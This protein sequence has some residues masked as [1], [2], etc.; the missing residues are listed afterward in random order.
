MKE[1]NREKSRE[2]V[3]EEKRNGKER[4]E[5]LVTGRGRRK[6]QRKG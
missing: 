3:V 2:V 5:R 4:Q 6:T 1:G